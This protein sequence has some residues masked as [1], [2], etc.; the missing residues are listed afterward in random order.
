MQRVVD[1]QTR[2]LSP[3]LLVSSA[4][5]SVI[6]FNVLPPNYKTSRLNCRRFVC[7]PNKKLSMNTKKK[8]LSETSLTLYPELEEVEKETSVPE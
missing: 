2:L 8:L 4:L 5:K 7:R 6:L 1:Q 3:H